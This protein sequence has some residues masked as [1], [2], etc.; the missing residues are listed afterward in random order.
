VDPQVIEHI[1]E[2]PEKFSTIVMVAGED[3]T[4]LPCLFVL[5]E[6]ELSELSGHRNQH[7]VVDML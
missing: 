2:F 1:G 7:L 5:I 3:S 4:K 6:L